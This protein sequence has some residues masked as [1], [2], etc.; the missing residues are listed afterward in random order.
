[1]QLNIFMPKFFWITPN[2][3]RFSFE[4]EISYENLSLLQSFESMLNI[5]FRKH[6]IEIVP[7]YHT[8]TVYL[9]TKHQFNVTEVLNY[10]RKHSIQK[11]NRSSKII[12]IPVCYDE[13]FAIDMER[14]IEYT[15]LSYEEIVNIHS[16]KTYEVF[17]MGFLPGFPYLGILDARL[18]VPRLPKARKNVEAGSVGIGGIQTGIYSLSSPGGWNILGRTPVQLFNFQYKPYFFFSPQVKVRID[19][20][21]KTE[22]KKIE[23]RGLEL[24]KD[25][26]KL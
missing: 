3:I 21:S 23:E 15:G 22:F 12:T 13:E 25:Y 1:M 14:I 17:L 8:V 20:I 11:Q 10:W 9:K 5:H 6:L 16:S 19:R 7:G 26:L 24:W 18:R 4:E 2:I